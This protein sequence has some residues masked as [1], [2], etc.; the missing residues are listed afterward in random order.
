MDRKIKSYLQA[1]LRVIPQV[2]YT[3]QQEIMRMQFPENSR[4]PVKFLDNRN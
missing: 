1:K 3:T 2:R 4:K